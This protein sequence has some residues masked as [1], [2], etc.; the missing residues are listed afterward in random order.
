MKV[1]VGIIGGTGI[2]DRLLELRGTPVHIPTPVGVLRGRLTESNGL[3][4]LVVGRHSSGHKVP[5]HKVNYAAMALGMK[6]VGIRYCLSTAAVG[7][8]RSD[9]G[10]GTLVSCSDFLDFSGRIPTLFDRTVTHTDFSYPFSLRVREKIGTASRAGGIQIVDDGVYVCA[11]GPRYETPQEIEFY[12]QVGGDLVGMTA[13][14][15][16]ILM[17]EAGIEYGCLAI[18]TNFASGIS[19]TPLNHLAVV[20]EMNRSGERAVKLLLATATEL[21][22]E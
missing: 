11:N 10:P 21:R 14:S 7:S 12:R 19:P 3:E 1:H 22:K 15:E 8:L 2:G 13:T 9:W 16:A 6:S 20:E 5:P 18:V 17:R 4:V